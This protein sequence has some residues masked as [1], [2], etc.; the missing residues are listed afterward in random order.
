MRNRRDVNRRTVALHNMKMTF[1][2]MKIQ[3]R[4]EKHDNVDATRENLKIPLIFFASSGHEKRRDK[5]QTG[6]CDPLMNPASVEGK[7]NANFRRKWGVS[8]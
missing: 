2:K 5:M 4:T 1:C 3:R 7:Q 8:G 6:L